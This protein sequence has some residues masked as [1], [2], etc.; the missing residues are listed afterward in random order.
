MWNKA[1]WLS[2][3]NILEERIVCICVVG[4]SWWNTVVLDIGID[5][6]SFITEDFFVNT[7]LKTTVSHNNNNNNNNIY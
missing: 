2:D 3:A 7:I 4:G 1:V 5:V 6:L